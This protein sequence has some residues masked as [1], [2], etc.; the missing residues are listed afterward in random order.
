M[1]FY[2]QLD[3]KGDKSTMVEN[4]ME[5]EV[6]NIEEPIR[7]LQ[8]VRV[9]DNGGIEKFI[10]SYLENM[11]RD[12]VNFDFLLTRN[13]EESYDEELKSL[14]CRKEIVE[15]KLTKIPVIRCVESYVKLK[16]FF[17]NHDYKI[18]HFQSVGETIGGAFA[19]LAAKHAGVPVRIVHGHSAAYDD[20]VFYKKILQKLGRKAHMAWG[21]HWF[22]CSKEAA[23]LSF[24]EE[25]CNQGKVQY[26]HNAIHSSDYQ[27]FKEDR[28][29]IRKE[30][31]IRE[32]FVIGNIGR[33]SPPKNHFFMVDV[34]QKI[35]E[36][37]P[38]AMLLFVG[39]YSTSY[40][41][42][43]ESIRKYVHKMGLDNKVIF[44]GE[45]KDANRL[46]NAMDVFLFPSLWEGLGIVAVEAQ[47][48]GLPVVA[49][50][51][52]P[53]DTKL[54]DLI[55]YVDLK[56]TLDIWAEVIL[57]SVTQK[58]RKSHGMEIKAKGYD[59]ETEAVR[60]QEIY[61]KLIAYKESAI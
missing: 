34:L 26:I 1:N 15:M 16:R 22:A 38:D 59:L 50:T 2:M 30:L 31:G 20:E 51:K 28:E 57:K 25:A 53:K 33:M 52:V 7:I 13:Q 27:Y 49:S 39:G 6:E 61:Q 47:A 29:T 35:L 32:K 36:K 21:T 41:G 18:I 11:D 4:T 24:G 43:F 46:L 8:Y 14:R 12:K 9:L 58:E 42:Y 48:N 10:F 19:I 60:L 54:T 3:G 56:D 17:T 44:T 40:N 45:R 55:Q 37:R 23:L 5:K